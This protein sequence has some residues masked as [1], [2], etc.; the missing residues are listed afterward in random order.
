MTFKIQL[1]TYSMRIQ[2]LFLDFY[3]GRLVL[4][5]EINKREVQIKAVYDWNGNGNKNDMF[6]NVMEYQIYKKC[7]STINNSTPRSSTNSS[8]GVF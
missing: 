4:S 5:K 6:D 7:T 8:A 3:F 1:S 2:S